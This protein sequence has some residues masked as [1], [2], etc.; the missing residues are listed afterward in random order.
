MR[1][2]CSAV[3]GLAM[4]AMGAM[5]SD[6]PQW[7]GP[8]RS[9]IS[10][11]TGWFKDGAAAR[12]M[13]EVPVG[14]GYSSVVI[15]S[16]RLYTMGNRTN[17]DV[18]VCLDALK[19]TVLWEFMY[20]CPAVADGFSGPRSTPTLDGKRLYT[21]SHRGD[22]FCLDAETGVRV[23]SR[24]L[25][26]D[27]GTKPLGYGYSGSPVVSGQSVFLNV[28]AGGV[29]LDKTTGKTL[30]ASTEK[31][32]GYAAAVPATFDGQTSV[33]FFV[34]RAVVS[35]NPDNGQKQ[36]EYPWKTTCNI[37]AADPLVWGDKVFLS[38]G[39]GHG[40]ALL[41]VSAGGPKLLWET[42]TMASHFTSPVLWKG[43]LYGVTGNTGEGKVCC[44]DPANGSARWLRKETGF[45][46]LTVADGK[47]VLLNE[48]GTLMVADAAED[49]Y[50]ERFSGKVLDGTCW[51]AP[52]V[53]NG[54]VYVRNDKG[55]LIA[56]DLRGTV[57]P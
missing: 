12:T 35:L 28:S 40:G 47:L 51:T 31:G 25:Q 7:R 42:K 37:N 49:A 13:W 14:S 19:G 36:W 34:E 27:P 5:A 48:K 53:C 57:A 9:G 24:E 10:A 3:V 45:C 41:Q 4:M 33:L 50:H 20:S 6:W 11:E 52:V 1:V 26:K 16:G 55:R 2:M 43:F 44:V 30:W 29:A 18:V 15:Q 38:S 56:L 22:V 17:T 8:E 21:M 54:L 39:Y 46:A 23:W 32:A